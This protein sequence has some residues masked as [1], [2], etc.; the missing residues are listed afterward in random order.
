VDID[1]QTLFTGLK[2]SLEESLGRSVPDFDPSQ[3]LVGDLGL[4]SL[5]LL[6]LIF[7]LERRFKIRLNTRDYEK[8][9][10]AQ[11]GDQPLVENGQY[12]AA[13]LAEF[14]K[15]MP[16]IPPAELKDGLLVT[17]LVELFRVQTFINMVKEGFRRKRD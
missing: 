13:A 14:K 16:C 17:E 4:D 9:V 6:D 2:E 8:R 10:K 1:E 11:L 5:D 7:R 15:C 12:T 3:R